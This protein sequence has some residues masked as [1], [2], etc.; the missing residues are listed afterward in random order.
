LTELPI[1]PVPPHSG[2]RR[3]LTRPAFAIY[4]FGIV[5]MV[6][7]DAPYI[8][9]AVLYALILLLAIAQ[10]FFGLPRRRLVGYCFI[11][12]NFYLFVG[13]VGLAHKETLQI[14]HMHEMF[15][16]IEHQQAIPATTRA[17]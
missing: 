8:V 16:R 5:W 4:L 13:F 6:A 7:V 2:F 12:L 17:A 9:S 14:R 10:T 1:N 3:K 11:V 15:E